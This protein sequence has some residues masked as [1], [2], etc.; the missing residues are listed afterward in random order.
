MSFPYLRNIDFSEISLGTPPQSFKVVLDTGSSNRKLNLLLYFEPLTNHFQ[1][2]FPP[3]SV[4]RS[5]AISTQS[6]TRH[7][8][9]LTRPTVPRL[10]SA[11]ALVA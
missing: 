11:T 3:P 9:R 8:P 1:F 4:A 2:G 6:M 10:R 7:R 5:L